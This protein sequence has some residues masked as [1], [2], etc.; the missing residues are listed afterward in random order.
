MAPIVVLRGTPGAVQFYQHL[1]AEVEE[2]VRDGVGAIPQERYRLLWDNIAIWHHLYRFYNYFVNYDA[3]FVVD[4]YTG[5]WAH[6]VPVGDL[7]EGLASAYATVF[8]NQSL[9]YRTELVVGLISEYD[10]DGFVMHNNRSCKP[11]SLGQYAIKRAAAERTGVPGLIIESDMC[12][13]RAFA[14]EAVR[15]RIQAFMETLAAG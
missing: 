4:T 10:V 12:D 8:L 2:R 7:L 1:R 9:S 3:C 13:S 6:Q 11:Y 14:R 5:G 15:T